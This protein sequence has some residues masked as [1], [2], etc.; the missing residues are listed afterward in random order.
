MS[1][2]LILFFFFSVPLLYHPWAYIWRSVN[3]HRRDTCKCMFTAVLVTIA[4]LWNQQVDKENMKYMQWSISQP[5]KEWNYVI[6]GR[7]MEAEIIML[8]K[9]SQT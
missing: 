2:T 4:K 3:Q 7:R 1:R 6:C 9:I 8:S 5:W